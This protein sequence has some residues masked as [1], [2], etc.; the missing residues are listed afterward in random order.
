MIGDGEAET[1]PLA[2]SWFSNRF[3]NPVT[4]GAVLPILHLNGF[5]ISNP[6]I[7]SR[8]SKEEIT[9]YFKGMGWQP[10]FIEGEDPDLMHP[11]MAKVLDTIVERIEEI[12]K[13]RVRT[14]IL[15]V[16]SGQCWSSALLRVGQVQSNGK[17]CPLII[18]SVPIRCQFRLTKKYEIRASVA[19]VAEQL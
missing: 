16:R 3:I 4:D 10:F 11:E 9:A 8:Q 19:G 1:G 13:M 12:Q 15:L 7:L 5:K 17:V 6:T 14:M 2:T 18:R